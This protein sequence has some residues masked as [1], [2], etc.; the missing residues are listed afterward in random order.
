MRTGKDDNS[1]IR[2]GLMKRNATNKGHTSNKEPN[3]TIGTTPSVSKR[4]EQCVMSEHEKCFLMFHM[5]GEH[6]SKSLKNSASI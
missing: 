2:L 6:G 4:S 5:K 3:R 1:T